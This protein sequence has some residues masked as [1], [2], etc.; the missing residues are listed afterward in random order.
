VCVCIGAHET[1][2]YHTAASKLK[3]RIIVAFE[4]NF[5]YRNCFFT[6]CSHH[7]NQGSF[8]PVSRIMRVLWRTFCLSWVMYILFLPVYFV[9]ISLFHK[10]FLKQRGRK[11]VPVS[12]NLYVI[13]STTV[14]NI[15]LRC[16]QV[17]SADTTVKSKSVL[18]VQTAEKCGRFVR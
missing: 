15:L 9:L 12:L 4:F 5:D 14:S 13:L 8:K 7:F 3:S 10:C 2:N 17:S 6:S 11:C 1:K 18:R 16:F